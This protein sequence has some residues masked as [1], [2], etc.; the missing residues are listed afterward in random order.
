MYQVRKDI[1]IFSHT[2]YSS[3]YLGGRNLY[4]YTM[5]GEETV[6]FNRS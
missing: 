2:K 5:N 3:R 4:F 6:L 1:I